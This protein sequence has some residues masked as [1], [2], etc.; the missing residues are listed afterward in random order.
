M[1]RVLLSGRLTK[2]PDINIRNNGKLTVANFVLA[3]QRT[4]APKECNYIQCVAFGT[5]AENI[6]KYLKQ[7]IKIIVDDGEWRTDEYIDRYGNKVF[8]NQC[9]VKHFEFAESKTKQ[10]EH[11]DN[12][13]VN[14]TGNATGLFPFT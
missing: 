10:T 9:W 4:S 1:N 11:G 8:T 3:V 12:G 5:T 13:F 2:D 6:R 7:G 14:I